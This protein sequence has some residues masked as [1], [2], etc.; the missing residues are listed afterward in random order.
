MLKKV[1][2]IVAIAP[3]YIETSPVLSHPSVRDKVRVIPL[4]IDERSYPVNGEEHIL[5]RLGLEGAQDYFLFIGV[6][7]YYKGLHFLLEAAKKV[8]SQIVIA[9]TGP[10]EKRL[11]EQCEDL[12]LKNV[13]FAGQVSNSEKVALLKKCR[14]LVLPSH[15]RSE[16]FGMVLVE[17]SMF[18]KP[19]ISCEIGTG[20]S[21]IN[22]HEE[23]G[24]VVPPQSPDALSRAM[25]TLLYDNDLALKM[26]AS[27]RVRYEQ[28]FSGEALGKAY[29][30]L[31]NEVVGE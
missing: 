18:S 30:Q 9:G 10:E 19:L 7:R 1:S 29:A 5:E 16:A 11:K 15:L 14:A 27:A 28:L 17:A 2:A 20:T 13:I 22:S 4:G 25:N 8:R 23:T 3:S 21:F 26:G 12:R 31:F 24:F 6:L